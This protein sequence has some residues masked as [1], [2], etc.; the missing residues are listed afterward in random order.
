MSEIESEAW[1]DKNY[2]AINIEVICIDKRYQGK[3]I[4]T[5]VLG[6]I[7]NNAKEVSNFIGCRY[8][9]LDALKDRVG[10]YENRGF[11][12]F[13]K[14]DMK[15]DCPTIK[16]YIDFS[17]LLISINKWAD[18]LDHRVVCLLFNCQEIDFYFPA[19]LKRRDLILQYLCGDLN[20]VIIYQCH[21]CFLQ[22]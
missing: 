22:V 21:C 4:G 5:T 2:K 13:A 15:N 7:I 6:Y 3:N 12:Y 18:I 17:C 16:M 10:W 19:R 20:P 9:I 8:L 1:I 11:S 14:E